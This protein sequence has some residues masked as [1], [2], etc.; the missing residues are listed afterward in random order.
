CKSH[1][2][3]SVLIKSDALCI[4]EV[5]N[6]IVKT[7]A[8]IIP[9]KEKN[10]IIPIICSNVLHNTM[11]FTDEHKRYNDLSKLGFKHKTVCHKYNF[12]NPLRV[13]ILSISKALIM[14]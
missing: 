4:V 1:K 6:N 3:R 11:I 12:V 2:G 14:N 9:N 7:F 8:T 13:L 5:K 10:T